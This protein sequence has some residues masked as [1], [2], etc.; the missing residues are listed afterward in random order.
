MD[1]MQLLWIP[2]G[3]LLIAAFLAVPFVLMWATRY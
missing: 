3:I 1:D 2:F